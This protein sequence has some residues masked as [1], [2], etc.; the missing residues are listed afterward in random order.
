MIV[1]MPNSIELIR[2]AA[3]EEFSNAPSTAK[4]SKSF[5][6]TQT[7]MPFDKTSNMP[8]MG[9]YL[10]FSTFGDDYAVNQKF[11]D[12]GLVY[13]HV[14]T[15]LYPRMD[16]RLKDPGNKIYGTCM[17]C[18]FWKFIFTTIILGPILLL[19]C[20][21]HEFPDHLRKDKDPL[22]ESDLDPSESTFDRTL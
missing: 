8:D 22:Q 5:A 21:L 20:G 9:H 16:P 11:S 7:K 14:M 12:T 10:M 6:L 4:S 13:S 18:P 17:V 19:P 2:L 3:V 15:P 1:N